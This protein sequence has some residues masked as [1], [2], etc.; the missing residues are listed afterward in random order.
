MHEYIIGN[1]NDKVDKLKCKLEYQGF[2]ITIVQ[3]VYANI[4]SLQTML[5]GFEL[6]S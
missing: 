1:D 2:G 4:Q 3:T 6:I 5:Y